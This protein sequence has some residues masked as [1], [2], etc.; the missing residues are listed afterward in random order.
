MTVHEQFA[1][2]LALHALGCLPTDERAGLEAHLR[3]CSDCRQELEKL[4]GDM[5]LMALAAAGPKPPARARQRL[6]DAIAREPR[7]EK[8]RAGLWWL[9]IVRFAVVT[10][11]LAALVLSW[12]RV[13]RLDERIAELQSQLNNQ[14]ADLQ[15]ARDIV[16]TLTATDAMQ[17]T[18][19][20]AKT[21]PQPQ[22][23][24]MY[25]KDRSSLI[26]MASNLPKL[27]AKKAY[28]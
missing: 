14:Q 10:L 7:V 27:P 28:E 13:R 16:A 4:R 23:K 20:A 5:A 15:R 25:V 12:Q 21:P 26:F 22:G 9:P 24:A 11:V 3:D 8:A 6:A 1:E 17:V 19:V 2:D 18:L